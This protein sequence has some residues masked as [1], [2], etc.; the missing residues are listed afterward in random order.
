MK[1]KKRPKPRG[2]K[3]VRY[4]V[5]DKDGDDCG[6]VAWMNL[7]QAEKKCAEL[8]L[9]NPKMGPFKAVRLTGTFTPRKHR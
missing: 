2:K 5:V 4:L 1:A 3:I 9:Y 8:T 6:A 7:T